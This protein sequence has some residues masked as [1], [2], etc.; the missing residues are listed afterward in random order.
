MEKELEEI[1]NL[2]LYY[3]PGISKRKKQDKNIHEKLKES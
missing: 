2:N 3:P 1:K